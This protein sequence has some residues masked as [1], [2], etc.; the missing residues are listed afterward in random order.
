M[1]HEL[2]QW[3]AEVHVVQDGVQ[4]C[5]EALLKQQLGVVEHLVFPALCFGDSARDGTGWGLNSCFVLADGGFFVL[6]CFLLV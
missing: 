2:R 1:L 3:L 6:F 4:V 5:V